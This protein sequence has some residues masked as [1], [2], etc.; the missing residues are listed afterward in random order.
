[1]IRVDIDLAY[2]KKEG[3][4]MPLVMDIDLALDK[5]LGADPNHSGSGFGSRDIQYDGIW[6]MDEEGEV[7]Y[8]KGVP[9]ETA[10]QEMVARF[11]N[12]IK[13]TI[14]ERGAIVRYIVISKLVPVE[15]SS[16][17]SPE[18]IEESNRLVE[19]LK[20]LENKN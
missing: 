17:R 9:E 5:V 13:S 12:R 10:D 7:Q 4:V 20:E 3:D 6:L 15:V 11:L 14:K 19:S 2:S 16:Y 18:W 1:M 8:N